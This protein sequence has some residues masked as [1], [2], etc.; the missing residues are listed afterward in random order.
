MTTLIFVKFMEQL[1]IHSEIYFLLNKY[2]YQVRKKIHTFKLP[3]RVF[4]IGEG[5]GAREKNNL[6]YQDQK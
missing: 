5:E 3:N 6:I 4:P 2:I 1:L